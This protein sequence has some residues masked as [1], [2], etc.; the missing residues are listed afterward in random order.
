MA[1]GAVEDGV[2]DDAVSPV[3]AR[4]GP[5]HHVPCDLIPLDPHPEPVGRDGVPL[6]DEGGEDRLPMGEHLGDG[7]VLILD[8]GWRPEPEIDLRNTDPIG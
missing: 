3:G 6:R 4:V 1:L 5:L 7:A 2:H 8:A